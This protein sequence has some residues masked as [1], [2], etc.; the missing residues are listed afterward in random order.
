MGKKRRRQDSDDTTTTS[1]L[2]VTVGCGPGPM[3]TVNVTVTATPSAPLAPPATCNIQ[4]G[5]FAT[6]NANGIQVSCPQL[7]SLVVGTARKYTT[8][9]VS[10]TPGATFDATVNVLWQIGLQQT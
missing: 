7:M 10:Q 8:T 5:P 3:G 6:L 9:F 2:N 1:P 4:A